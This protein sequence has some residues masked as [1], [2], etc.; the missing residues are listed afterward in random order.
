METFRDASLGQLLRFLTGKRCL[1]YPEES[2]P[3]IWA[4]YYLETNQDGQTG[5]DA[6]NEQDQDP[7]SPESSGTEMQLDA[8]VSEKEKSYIVV[9]WRGPNDGDVGTYW[10]E[11][12][13]SWHINCT[14]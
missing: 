1:R 3:S 8:G 12:M 14:S 4:Q 7:G 10:V 2:D 5:S 11:Q 9:G 13:V 6:R